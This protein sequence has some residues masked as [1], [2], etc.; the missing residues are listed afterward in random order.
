MEHP[1]LSKYIAKRTFKDNENICRILSDNLN[2][3]CTY[4]GGILPPEV[5]IVRCGEMPQHSLSHSESLHGHN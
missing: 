4:D 2:A 1:V 3:R 5:V